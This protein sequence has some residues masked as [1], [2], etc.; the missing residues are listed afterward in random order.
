MKLLVKAMIGVV[1]VAGVVVMLAVTCPD[2]DSF[3]RWA[4]E[5]IQPESGSV[6][7]QAKRAALAAQAK[8]TADCE[9]HVL[10]A[11][12]DAYQGGAERR[13]VGVLGTWIQVGGE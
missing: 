1:V 12:V 6:V 11:T 9:D 3:K 7:E 2:E 10:W 8:W 13:Y 4:K 5:N